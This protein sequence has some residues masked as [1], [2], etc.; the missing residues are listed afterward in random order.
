M[1]QVS[2]RGITKRFAGKPPT[3]AI[4]DLSIDIEEGEFLVLLGPSGCGKTTTLRCLAGLES[5][6]EGSIAIGDKTVFD[7]STRVNLPPDKRDLGMVFQSY[8]LWPHMTVAKNIGYP[9]KARKVREGLKEGW[10]QSTAAMV[11]CAGLLDRYPA[12]LSGGQQQRVALA[13]GLVA[14]PGLVLFDEPLS[15]LDARLRDL[16]RSELAE[17]HGRLSFSAVYVTHD[18][19]EALALGDRM[20]I[21][22]SGRV[23]Q[24]DTPRRVFEAPVSEY[25]AQFIGME[26]RI[27]L[28]CRDG[29]WTLVGGGA[30]AD[31]GQNCLETAELGADVVLRVRA[32]D[33]EIHLS[34]DSVPADAVS[35]KASVA[36]AT[37][38]G[39]HLEAIVTVGACRLRAR[40][41]VRD[42]GHVL[43]PG[44]AV[45]VS[46]RP[47]VAAPF[48]PDGSRASGPERS[49]VG[50]LETAV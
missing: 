9:L 15:N 35:F 17:L 41:P 23:E 7:R 2:I 24:L 48:T 14:R 40:V 46:I 1:S 47:A 45:T 25:V 49:L 50:T 12:Q 20:A 16:V 6:D 26:N 37:Y 34:D 22:R 28:A 29:Q 18:Q 42:I 36:V 44:Q 43:V 3:V 31:T 32:D 38:G 13:R 30:G 19:S 4:D 11:D 33:V 21:M 39:R 10:V 27:V 8:A 5:A